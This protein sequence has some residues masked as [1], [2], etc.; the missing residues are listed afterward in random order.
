MSFGAMDKITEHYDDV[1]KGW[2]SLLEQA[3]A[4][5]Q[6][7]DPGY[8]TLQVKE[9]FGGLRLYING[10]KAAQEI[11]RQY[12]RES[13]TICEYCG[14]PGSMTHI[15]GWYNTLCPEHAERKK[16]D[17]PYHHWADLEVV[18]QPP[19]PGRPIPPKGIGPTGE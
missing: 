14:A 2:H 3:H 1:G 18:E 12:E 6:E 5:V 4:A 15:G 8:Q 7:A 11:V 13:Y 9:K 10:S 17:G 19:I 16:T